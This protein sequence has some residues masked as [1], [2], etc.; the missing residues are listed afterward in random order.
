MDLRRYL[1]L[2]SMDKNWTTDWDLG[3]TDDWVE[4]LLTEKPSKE[5]EICIKVKK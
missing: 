1:E 3:D 4:A 5:K 2:D